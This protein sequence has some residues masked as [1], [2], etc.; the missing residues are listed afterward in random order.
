MRHVLEGAFG[1]VLLYPL[2]WYGSAPDPV[3]VVTDSGSGAHAA[4]ER[5]AAAGETAPVAAAASRPGE[6][7]T[8]RGSQRSAETLRRIESVSGNPTSALEATVPLPHAPVAP[9]VAR[10]RVPQPTEPTVASPLPPSLPELLSR[11]S[12]VQQSA[13]D[14]TELAKRVQTLDADPAEL[15]Q[16]REFADRFVKLPPPAADR[17]TS[18]STSGPLRAPR[19]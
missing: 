3:D 5:G 14:P 17:Y 19:R 7:R 13:S 11:V 6:L 18:G 9:G 8:E 16:L 15:A 4:A 2:I 10:P 1:A 12:D